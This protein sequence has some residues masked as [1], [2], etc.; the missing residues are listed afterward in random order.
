MLIQTQFS[1]CA[2]D[3]DCTGFDSATKIV[4]CVKKMCVCNAG[5]VAKTNERGC[6]P[7]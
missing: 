3:T 1:D 7:G 4:D 6:N 2:K 5:Y